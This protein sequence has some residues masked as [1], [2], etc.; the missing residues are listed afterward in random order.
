MRTV[1]RTAFALLVGSL[2]LGPLGCGWGT[3]TVSGKVTYNDQPLTN[4]TV[5]FSN[6]DGKGNRTA[7]IQADGTYK[8]EGMPVGK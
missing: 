1:L 4:G 3:G 7:D 8:I 2:A 5:I 6:A